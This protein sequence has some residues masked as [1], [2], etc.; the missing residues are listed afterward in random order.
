MVKPYDCGL[1]CG[2]FQTFHIGHESL[3]DTGMK[4]CDRV[5]ILI[6]S[7]QEC[8]TE[9]NP[10][11]I[12]TRMDMLK[13]IYG[14]RSDVMIYG[15]SDMT[16]ENDIRPEWGKYLLENVDRYIYKAPELMIYG[17]DESRS[18]WFAPEDIRDTSEL[19]VNRGRI[20]ISATMVRRAMVFD[21]RKEWMSMVN[22]KLHK[23]YDRLRDE[24][25]TVPFYQEMFDQ[26]KEN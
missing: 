3:V 26:R 7:A 10:Y 21:R 14:D 9:R 1:I 18:R 4:L 12:V 2:R 6:G 5:L 22:P 25:M 15:L 20:P 19:I 8:G 16:D 23:M 11:N 24:L 17:N 13:S